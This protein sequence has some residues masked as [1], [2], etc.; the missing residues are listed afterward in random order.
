VAGIVLNGIATGACIGAGMGP[1]PRDGLTTGLA[2]RGLSLRA[3]RTG[4]EVGVLAAG[5]PLGGAVG[6][7]TVLYAVAIGPL[8]HRTLP[9]LRIRAHGG[10]DEPFRPASA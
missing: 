8:V 9:A 5:W 10:A 4:I 7:G 2:E 6:I 1:G 3:V